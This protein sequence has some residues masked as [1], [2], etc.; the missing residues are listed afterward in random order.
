MIIIA[1]LNV[2]ISIP[3]FD[4]SVWYVVLATIIGTIFAWTIDLIVAGI[5]FLIPKKF[6]SA[7]KFPFKVHKW[8]KGFYQKIG[9]RVW[10]DKIPIGAGPFGNGF[11]KDKVTDKTNNEYIKYFLFDSCRAETMHI[12]GAVFGFLL[13]V[14]FPIKYVW[15]FA[16]PIAFVN[17]VLQVLPIFTQRYTRPKLLKLYERNLKTQNKQQENEQ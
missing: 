12:L 8:E 11:R 10:K 9:I 17:F 5:T 1:L 3:I 7:Q 14:I 4:F 15:C 16:V 2:F 13:V 6:Y